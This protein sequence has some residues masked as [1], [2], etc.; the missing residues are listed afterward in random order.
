MAS[1]SPAHFLARY[2]RAMLLLQEKSLEIACFCLSPLVTKGRF[3]SHQ[4]HSDVTE[5]DGSEYMSREDL[6][7]LINW[8]SEAYEAMSP[9]EDGREIFSFSTVDETEE[10]EKLLGA[11]FSPAQTK[12]IYLLA[13]GLTQSDAAQRV[14]VSRRTIIRWNKEAE[15]RAEVQSLVREMAE[16]RLTITNNLFNRAARALSDELLDGRTRGWAAL[17]ILRMFGPERVLGEAVGKASTSY[18]SSA[19]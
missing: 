18:P 4:S 5:K 16:T 13:E 14:G 19:A 17:N 12:A 11:I 1:Y 15:F 2:S 8:L 10:G 3:M 6:A 7:L 9:E